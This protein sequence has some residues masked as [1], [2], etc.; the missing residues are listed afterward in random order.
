MT[1]VNDFPV[2]VENSLNGDSPRPEHANPLLK[3]SP[4]LMHISNLSLQSLARSNRGGV[5]VSDLREVLEGR[6][7]MSNIALSQ[8][9]APSI[10]S[11]GATHSGASGESAACPSVWSASRPRQRLLSGESRR[12]VKDV[13]D[14]LG[15]GSNKSTSP[16]RLSTSP[17][18][19]VP[20]R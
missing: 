19:S 11:L 13:L 5:G 8:G 14:K 1:S 10:A 16:P 17:K 2:A 20:V 15:I 3:I 4:A 6:S 18:Q 9:R 12:D 7:G